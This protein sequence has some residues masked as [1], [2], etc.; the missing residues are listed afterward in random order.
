MPRATTAAW[1]VMP[2]RAVRMP[3]RRVHAVNVLGAGLDADEDHLL[4]RAGPFLGGVGVEHRL[5]AGRAGRGGQAL[6]DDVARRRRDRAS[7]G[8]T[9]RAPRDRRAAPPPPRVISPS[10]GHVDGDPQRRLGGALAGA[11]LQHPQLAALDG[12]LD[13]LHVAIMA[14]EQVEDARRARRTP[15]AS[16]LPSTAP[17]RP[18]SRARPGS[19]IAAC[20]C[21]RRRPRPGR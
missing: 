14:L 18:P 2:P 1:L 13:V 3:L 9:G 15:P 17:W 19:D 11:G 7:G 10:L 21:R 6:G 12:E 16:S 4:A 20:G 8:A 5:A